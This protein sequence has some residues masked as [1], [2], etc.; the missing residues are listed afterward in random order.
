MAIVQSTLKLYSDE[1]LTQLIGTFTDTSNDQHEEIT[2][3]DP[4]TKYYVTV[5]TED[6][7]GQVSPESSGYPF[8]SLPQVNF[9]GYVT[10]NDDGFVRSMSNTTTDVQV[11]ENGICWDTNSNFTNPTYTPGTTVSGLQEHTLY[12]YRPYCIDEQGRRWVNAFDTDSVT[13]LYA[14]PSIDW[15]V[16]YGPTPT[17]YSAIINVTSLASVTAVLAEI[18][19]G[20]ITTT[21]SLI[22][23]T[24]NQTITISNL[25][26]NTNYS[27]RIKAINQSGD[28]YSLQDTFTTLEAIEG[29]SV[30]LVRPTISNIDNEMTVTSIASYDSSEFTL[31]SHSIEIYENEYHSGSP[32]DTDSDTTDSITSTFTGLSADTT[33]WVFGKVTYTVGSDPT[34]LTAWSEPDEVRTYALLSFGTITPNQT[35]ASIPFSVLGT[36]LLVEVDYSVDNVNWTSIPISDP[37]GETLQVTGLSPNTLYYLRGRA[38]NQAGWQEYVTDDFT[39]SGLASITITSVS[40]ITS[41]SAIVNVQINQ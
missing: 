32:I 33:Y 14:V 13:T 15:I 40:N 7:L 1:A 5:T 19:T 36:A 18:T 30:T 11:V 24:G 26:P 4:G 41:T 22:A 8:Y 29:M 39:T 23:Q 38:Q 34:I 21:Q 37:S 17:T 2:G 20:G 3:L 35:G 12:F 9:T 25:T 28:G 6:S 10:R 31:V 27:I 16:I